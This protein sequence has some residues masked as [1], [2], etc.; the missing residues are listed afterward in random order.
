MLPNIKESM[1]NYTV[2]KIRISIYQTIPLK[3]WKGKA[4]V[5]NDISDTYNQQ[6]SS[7]EII[8]EELL[9]TNL[10]KREMDKRLAQTL[11]NGDFQIEMCLI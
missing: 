1:I 5:N 6:M 11:Y 3:K 9:Q 4:R 8:Y 10:P 7:K 2:L